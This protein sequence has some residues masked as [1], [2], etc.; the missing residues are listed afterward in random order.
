MKAILW[1]IRERFVIWRHHP[2]QVLFLLGVPVLSIV[3]YLFIYNNSGAANTL[4]V[5]IVD[6]DQSAYSQQF[7]AN[8]DKRMT[9]KKMTSVKAADEAL[10]DQEIT[11]NIVI[12][13]DF[14]TKIRAGEL[15]PLTLRSF[16]QGEAIDG[17]KDTAKNTYNEVLA[18]AKFARNSNE[19]VAFDYV[20]T[21]TPLEFKRV[22]TDDASKAMSI[23]ILG[24]MLM[25]LLYQ[26]G[27]FGANSI[28]NERR[29]K[30]YQRMLTTP[31][32]RGAYFAGT[33]IFAFLAMLF[34][35]IFTV[36]LMTVVFHIDIGLAALQLSGL[37]AS[38]GLVGVAWSIAIGVNSPSTLVASGIQNILFTITSLLSGALI[39]SEIMPEFMTK[40]ARL[41]PQFWVLDAIRQL[42]ARADFTAILLN[43]AVLAAFGLLFFGIAIYGLMSKQKIGVFD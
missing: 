14:A 26:S 24:F 5:G 28:Q 10:A 36:V 21:T 29:N 23:Q 31:V 41:T 18:V 37:L 19:K 42:Q 8:F 16:Q 12:P 35:V 40:I 25:M 38:F 30:I 4:T 2:L 7:V 39:P 43:L 34:E 9:V 13:E 15:A 33:A 20:K 6:R 11:A 22:A 1:I 32:P 27:N 3:M 17:I